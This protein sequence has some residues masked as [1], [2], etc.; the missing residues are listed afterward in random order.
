MCDRIKE[1]DDRMKDANKILKNK[2]CYEENQE[3]SKCLITNNRDFRMCK[4][5]IQIL[6]ACLDRIKTSD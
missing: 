1:E 3:I 2:G 6:K 4:D 5:K